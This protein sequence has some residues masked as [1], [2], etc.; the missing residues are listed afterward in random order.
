MC[1]TLLRSYQGLGI[2]LRE[3]LCGKSVAELF[4]VISTVE[5]EDSTESVSHLRDSPLKTSTFHDDLLFLVEF[6][7]S[8]QIIPQLFG[9]NARLV[10]FGTFSFHEGRQET[11]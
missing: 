8:R 6:N 2:I 9:N 7:I 10:E 5:K 1:S 4:T 11:I 3:I